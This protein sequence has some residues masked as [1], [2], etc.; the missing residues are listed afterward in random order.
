MDNPYIAPLLACLV[1]AI[2][3]IGLIAALVAKGAV[4][5]EKNILESGAAQVRGAS[6]LLMGGNAS[7]DDWLVA[8]GLTPDSHFGDYLI[9]VWSGAQAGRVP[10]LTELHSLSA[11]RERR[12]SSA[13]LAGGITGLLVIGGI[14]ATLFCI[15]PVLT[16]FDMGSLSSGPGEKDVRAKEAN[17]MIQSLGGA[18]L[19]SLVALAAT[20]LVAIGRG[21]YQQAAGVLAWEL[22][23]FTINILFPTFRPRSFGEELV[24]LQIKLSGLV[25]QMEQRDARFGKLLQIAV[26]GGSALKALGMSLKESADSVTNA[27][28]SLK[29]EAQAV[30]NG[31]A[32][33]LGEGSPAVNGLAWVASVGQSNQ[34]MAQKLQDAGLALSAASVSSTKIVEEA[35]RQLNEAVS[36]IPARIEHGCAAG[37]QQLIATSHSAALAAAASISHAGAIATENLQQAVASVPQAIAR[38]TAQAG[39]TVLQACRDA[40][41]S[42]AEMVAQSAVKASSSLQLQVEP[43]RTVALQIQSANNTLQSDVRQSLGASLEHFSQSTTAVLQGFQETMGQTAAQLA[44]SQEAVT[45]AVAM[46]DR[47]IERVENLRNMPAWPRLCAQWM[48]GLFRR[49]G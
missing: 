46:T 44:T 29:T 26:T 23:R 2:G 14:A 13:R 41:K 3:L 17:T 12:R 27:S 45:A 24:E 35:G 4:A 6:R 38:G 37:S 8:Q 15:K 43:I 10:T 36:A 9:S 30:V 42:A 1:G 7:P 21:S 11:G 20:V 25:S 16:G 49:N 32:T 47:L 34:E 39:D 5:R 19:P 22:D 40:S 18:F 33:Y 31:F 28:D 48:K